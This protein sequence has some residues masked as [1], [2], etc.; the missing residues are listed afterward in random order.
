MK[1]ISLWQ[2]WASLWVSPRK[3]HD[4][5]HWQTSH[6]GWLAIH[7]AKKIET[8]VDLD[9]KDLLIDEFGKPWATTL[10]LGAIVGA[11]NLV[12]VVPAESLIGDHM[13]A[14]QLEDLL[15]GDF[16][17]GR[18]AWQRSEFFRLR[19]AVPF[20]GKQGFFEVPDELLA[21]ERVAQS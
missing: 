16:S 10:P 7:A 21:G 17:E 13:D 20:T 4:T 3:I 9:L 2:P 1:A 5:R 18:Y 11:I 8:D 14:A 15:G 6:R 12:D 19:D